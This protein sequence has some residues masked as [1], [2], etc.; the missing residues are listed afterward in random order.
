MINPVLALS[1]RNLWRH[2][3]RTWL[4]VGAM[5]FSN[6]LLV[7]M[8]TLQFGTYQMMIENSLSAYSSHLQIAANGYHD[9]PKMRNTVADIESFV[10]EIEQLIADIKVAPRAETFVL[11]SS[12]DRSFGLQLAGVDFAAEPRLS[13]IPGRIVKGEYLATQQDSGVVIGHIAARNLQVDV[14]AELT[15]LGSGMD[16]SFA[17]AVVTVRGIFDSGIAEIDRSLAQ[18][19][20]ADFQA[21]FSMSEHAHRIQL[22]VPD[23]NQVQTYKNRVQQLLDDRQLDYQLLDWQQMNPGIK[24]AIQSDLASAWV[25]YGVLILLVAFSVLN[26][27]LMSMLE[28]TREFGIMA[29]VGLRPI[30]L[31]KLMFLETAVMAGVGLLLGVLAGLCVAAYFACAGFGY[32]GMEAMADRYNLPAKMYPSLT[33]FSVMLGPVVVFVGCLLAAAY[34]AY[35]LFKLE[36]VAAMRSAAS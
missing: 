8:I 1:W 11:A 17:A 15:I 22:N 29:A 16:G 19:S 27:Q 23:I 28:R 5:V 18:M 20:L 24:Q 32:P 12:E 9:D 30:S 10:A 3:R 21:V 14:G 36:P 6:C 4:T 26:T 33:G 25:V 35:R 2:K 31:V 13:S 34:P 7:F